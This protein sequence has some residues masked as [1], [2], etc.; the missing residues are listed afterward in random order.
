[1]PFPDIAQHIPK[2]LRH[3]YVFFARSDLHRVREICLN[4][5]HA[6]VY[7]QKRRHLDEQLHSPFPVPPPREQS[8]RN[9]IWEEY[10]RLSGEARSR[11][12]DY[13]FAYLIDGNPAY[14]DKTWEG[15]SSIMN[16]PSW[17]HPVHEFMLLDLDSSH[18]NATFAAVYD[19][20]Y[21]ALTENQRRE[22]EYMVYARG[23]GLCIDGMDRFGWASNYKS[24][25]CSVCV[26]NMG[27][28]AIAMLDAGYIHLRTDIAPREKMVG[29]IR[30]SAQRLTKFFDA[31]EDDGS[32]KE[33]PGY[34]NYGVST[35]MPFSD[36]LKRLTGGSVDLFAHPRL[37]TT[38]DFPI[39]CYLPPDRVV[40]FADC[41][42]QFPGGMAYRKFAVEHNH[43]AASYFDRL[44]TD[45]APS[46]NLPELF[47]DASGVHP[48]LPDPPHPSRYF[49]DAGWC[50]MRSSWQDPNATV[51]ALK[52]GATV[53][54]HGHADVG[55][56]IVH[57][58]GKTVIRELGIGRYGDPGEAVF[59][60]T[61]GHNLPLFDG[62]GQPRDRRRL[63]TVEETQFTGT[64][65]YLR[66]SI[67][68][69]YGLDK[70]TTFV[71]HYL[72]LRPDC[73]VILDEIEVTEPTHLESRI[74]FAGGCDLDARAAS[75]S[76]NS[77]RIALRL[78]LPE[79]AAFVL[80]KHANLKPGQ[81]DPES[82]EVPY[83]KIET[84][85][86]PGRST[87]AVAF[88]I[89]TDTDDLTLRRENG[90]LVVSRGEQTLAVDAAFK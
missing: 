83:L 85:L 90:R 88:G 70:L 74:H 61:H 63:G 37:N 68:P 75:I 57:T 7:R 6:E 49:P 21:D 24:N 78:L 28:T 36:A 3:P 22:L 31:I 25:W 72:Y 67:A 8:Y 80:A 65:D 62:I 1:M 17:V 69:A 59:K 40:N 35:S 13:A 26:S 50:I 89:G 47:W 30:E 2:D 86:Q 82:L 34:W 54:P 38:V 9:G 32:W 33:G 84:D 53:E 5:S 18:T 73:F 27:L 29:I 39:N 81:A 20:L 52:I 60:D 11:V 46:L 71:R 79:D 4:G 58:H 66:A 44:T 87:Y 43:A 76:N 41:G 55:N 42:A 77:A 19:L 23:L 12:G 48:R 16:W 51:L 64:H 10:S 45:R 15:L 14:L 56:Y